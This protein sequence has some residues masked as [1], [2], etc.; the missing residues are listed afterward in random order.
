MGV[1]ELTLQADSILRACDERLRERERAEALSADQVVA[2]RMFRDRVFVM[3]GLLAPELRQEAI[4]QISL[5]VQHLGMDG[6]RPLA[7]AAPAKSQK[8]ETSK[9][10][11]RKP[12]HP[13]IRAQW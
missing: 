10:R 4:T 11:N 12:A 13:R 7:R 2:V 5:V 6:G 9:S 8:V 3:I 1:L